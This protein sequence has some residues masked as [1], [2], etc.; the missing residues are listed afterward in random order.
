M[1]MKHIEEQFLKHGKVT[2]DLPDV[3]KMVV[4]KCSFGTSNIEV[5]V[6]KDL[7]MRPIYYNMICGGFILGLK[8]VI[9]DYKN[10]N[11]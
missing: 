11:G 6:F 2:I 8:T 10:Q 9:E 5:K 7:S 1:N 3:S 4:K